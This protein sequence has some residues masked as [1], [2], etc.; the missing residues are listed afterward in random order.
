[1]QKAM[2]CRILRKNIRGNLVMKKKWTLAVL[3]A[4]LI[5][6]AVVCICIF[7][8]DT[9]AGGEEAS[10]VSSP[11]ASS[12][13]NTESSALEL[14]TDDFQ[15]EARIEIDG[16]VPQEGWSP[17][18]DRSLKLVSAGSYSGAYM[19][20][21]SDDAVEQVA[22]LLVQNVG[23]ET[24]EYAEV[25]GQTSSG[26]TVRFVLT[27]LPVNAYVLVLEAG[28]ADYAELGA[29]QV[30]E[31][32]AAMEVT[33]NYAEDFEIY[34]GD[35]VINIK[36]ISDRDYSDDIF[37]YYK[38]YREGVFLGGITYRARFNG[39][40]AQAIGQSIQSHATDDETAVV[41]MSYAQ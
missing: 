38:T 2:F 25:L 23:T 10:A 29:L 9:E 35:G 21:G 1:M 6:A 14:P 8:T 17:V 24:V 18:T 7:G 26:E 34:L 33:Q 13:Q 3:G 27:G 39:L 15:N 32:A 40:A 4:V 37:V 5:A 19:E 36:N 22:A 28:R 31:C 41:Y 20:D 12:A 30:T 16:F 11:Q